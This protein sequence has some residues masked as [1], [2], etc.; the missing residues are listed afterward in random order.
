[1]KF[2]QNWPNPKV[3]SLI[4]HSDVTLEIKAS[5]KWYQS[6]DDGLGENFTRVR[7]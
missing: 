4:F 1:M 6:Q 2:G 7:T 3:V 5:Y